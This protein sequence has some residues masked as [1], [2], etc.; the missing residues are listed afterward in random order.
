MGANGTSTQ[1]SDWRGGV[2]RGDGAF[3]STYFEPNTN[4]PDEMMSAAYCNNIDKIQ[5]CVAE[6]S[7]LQSR[8]SARSYHTGGVNAVM[9]DG[10]VHFFSDTIRRDHWRAVGTAQGGESSQIP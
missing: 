6:T 3:F 9:G 8:F 1:H 2:Y 5:P 4:Q 10:S 7:S